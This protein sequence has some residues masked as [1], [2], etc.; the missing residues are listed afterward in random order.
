MTERS[1]DKDMFAT[2]AMAEILLAQGLLDEARAAIDEAAGQT[3]DDPR[4]AQLRSRLALLVA[5]GEDGGQR[6]EKPRGMD[7]IDLLEDEGGT[8][9]VHWEITDDGREL[10]RRR[11]RFSGVD[12]L[13]LFTAAPGPRGVRTTTR[14]TALEFPTGNLK[15]VG[16]PGPAT[17]VCAIGFLANTGEFVPLARSVALSVTS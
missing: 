7:R 14:D 4:I 3:P 5:V 9:T 16:L 6:S 13:R 10:A 12:I 8:V 15:M 1:G 2:A 17:H 11:A